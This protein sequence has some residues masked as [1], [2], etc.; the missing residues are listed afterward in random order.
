MRFANFHRATLSF[1]EFYRVLPSFTEFY[2]VLPRNRINQVP[3]SNRIIPPPLADS[4]RVDT[5]TKYRVFCFFWFVIIFS[6]FFSFFFFW[7]SEVAPPIGNFAASSR[8]RG[9]RRRPVGRVASDRADVFASALNFYRVFFFFTEFCGRVC[10]CVRVCV[11]WSM[12][13]RL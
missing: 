13:V 9:P 7:A 6:I 2:R 10:V 1:T 11:W 5:I 8:R 3:S 12:M 4:Y